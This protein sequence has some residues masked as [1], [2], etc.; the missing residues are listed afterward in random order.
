MRFFRFVGWNWDFFGFSASFL[1][2]VHCLAL[3][4]LLS[5]GLLGGLA[6]LHQPP[7]EWSLIGSAVL[8]AGPAFYRGHRSH[9]RLLPMGMAGLGILLLAGSRWLH[10]YEHLLTGAGG[11]LIATAHW[12][13]WRYGRCLVRE[14]QQV[15]GKVAASASIEKALNGENASTLLLLLLTFSV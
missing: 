14:V 12:L 8:I 9:R 5:M 10:E 11:I 7:V 1:C 15:S 4:L 3:P 2:A 13:N 6:W